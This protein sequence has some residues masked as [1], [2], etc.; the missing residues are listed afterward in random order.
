MV[1]GEDSPSQVRVSLAGLRLDE[2]L[3][4]VQD[5][6]AEAVHTRDRMQGLLDSV[7]AVGS[8]LELEGTLRRIIETAVE[9]VD[10]RY[11]AVGVLGAEH[12]LSQFV[13]AG[14]DAETRAKMGHLPQGKGLLGELIEHSRPIRLP[15]LTQH[16]ASVGFPPNHPPMRTFLG[17]PIMVRDAVFGNIYLTEKRGGGG[18]TADDE[19]VLQALATAAGIAVDNAR[20]FERVLARERWLEATAEINSSLLGGASGADALRLIVDRVQALSGADC[21]LILLLDAGQPDRLVV[22]AGAGEH[23]DRLLAATVAVSEPAI[24]EVVAAGTPALIADLAHAMPSGLG[25]ADLEFGPAL[26]VPLG[27]ADRVGGVLLALR[28]KGSAQFATDQVPVLA[29]FADQTALALELA[30]KQRTQRQLDLLADRDRIAGDLHD[31]VIQQLFATGMSLQ[32]GVRRIADAEARRRVVRAIEQLDNTMRDIRTSIFDLNT[33]ADTSGVSL[34]RR[35]LDVINEVSTDS[36]VSPTIR[37]NGAVD[38]LVPPPLGEH[39]LAVLR[40]GVSNAIRHAQA[41]EIIV[42]VEVS[43]DG[44]ILDVVDDGVGLPAEVARSGLLGIERRAGECGGTASI[45]PGPRAA[46]T[47]LTW[48]APLR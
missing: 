28:D 21:A 46:G 12:G 4:E 23:A 19:V 31:H 20:L 45:G 42:T 17:V 1:D 2:L 40:E 9:L 29:S 7:L 38:T 24:A 44:M 14:I 18:F 34:R 5:R 8:G 33:G 48:R 26:A 22:R 47:R 35:M 37:I 3:G 11:G 13:Y 6:L 15:D 25:D 30:D 27:A 32:G 36:A 43:A 41:H 39:A 10:A 16:P